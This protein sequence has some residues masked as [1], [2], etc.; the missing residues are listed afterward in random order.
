MGHE[1]LLR[2]IELFDGIEGDDLRQLSAAM[3]ERRYRPGEIIVRMGDESSSAYIVVDGDANIHIP[4]EDSRRITLKDIGRGELFGELSLFDEKPRS[5][6]V[7]ATTDLTLLELQRGPYSAFLERRPKVAMAILRVMAARLRDTNA[8]LS[9]RAAKN[10][11]VEAEK[12]LGWTDRLADKVAELNGSWTFLIALGLLT[13]GWMIFNSAR[14]VGQPFDAYPFIF[15]N[16]V[17][18]ILVAVQGPLIVMSQNRQSLKDRTTA[19]IDFKVNLKNE[20]HIETI[21]RELGEF[22]AEMNARLEGIEHGAPTTADRVA[23]RRGS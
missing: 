19:E 8:M 3:I 4:G 6:S 2:G 1:E 16:L 7:V 9:E 12:Q 21:V 5:A 22:R 13:A 11:V 17:L 23:E 10:A 20:V 14:V 18:A 15:F